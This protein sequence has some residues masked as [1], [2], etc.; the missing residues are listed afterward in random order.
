MLLQEKGKG[1]E[2]LTPG[3]QCFHPYEGRVIG[4]LD[5]AGKL[6][7]VVDPATLSPEILSMFPGYDRDCKKRQMGPARESRN[8]F[9]V[10]V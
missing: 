3:G 8:C 6:V 4:R 10:G 2:S 5:E 9:M 7:P 1:P